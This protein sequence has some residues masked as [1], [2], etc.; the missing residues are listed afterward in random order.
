MG[1]GI[2]AQLLGIDHDGPDKENLIQIPG[3]GLLPEAHAIVRVFWKNKFLY[4]DPTNFTWSKNLKDF[5]PGGYSGILLTVDLED[6]K[7]IPQAYS[8]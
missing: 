6:F 8:F 7:D 2:F 3:K 4:C 5:A 1:K